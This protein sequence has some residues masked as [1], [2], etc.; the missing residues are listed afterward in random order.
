MIRM[1]GR[2]ERRCGSCPQDMAV[3]VGGAGQAS[4]PQGLRGQHGAHFRYG[5]DSGAG[6]AQGAVFTGRGRE[7]EREVG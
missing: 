3:G 2:S 6:E 1:Q 4:G 5:W 7:G